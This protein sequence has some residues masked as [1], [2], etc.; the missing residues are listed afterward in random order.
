MVF[1][2][3]RVI[4]I[5]LFE[6]IRRMMVLFI[7]DREKENEYFDENELEDEGSGM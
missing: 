4:L 2:E 5:F 3:E 7:K 1:F 6:K